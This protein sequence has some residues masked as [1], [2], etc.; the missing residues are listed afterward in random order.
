MAQPD[1]SAALAILQFQIARLQGLSFCVHYFLVPFCKENLPLAGA[2]HAG[3]EIRARI[4]PVPATG[5]DSFA[6]TC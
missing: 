2:K 4:A 6:M 5:L 3:I 1:V